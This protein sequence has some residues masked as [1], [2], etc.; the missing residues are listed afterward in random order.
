MHS[1]TRIEKRRYQR[2]NV[3]LSVMFRVM[4]PERIFEMVHGQ[5]FEGKT[6]DISL[7]GT[8]LISSYFLPPKARLFVKFIIYE[9]DHVGAMQSYEVLT[10]FAEVRSAVVH[11]DHRHYRL[12]LAFVDLNE[13]RLAKLNDIV[14][15]SLRNYD[16]P[17]EAIL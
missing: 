8:A 10:V 13:D 6:I 4:G 2:L 12:G 17:Q 7:G 3:N 1:T 16:L 15:S 5:E 9:T 14:E 11:N